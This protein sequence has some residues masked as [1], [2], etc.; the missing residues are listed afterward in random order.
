MKQIIYLLFFLLVYL[1]SY[2]QHAFKGKVYADVNQNGIIDKNEKGIA[3]VA[4]SNGDDVVLTDQN[5]MYTLPQRDECIVFVI[6]PSNFDLPKDPYY[7]HKFF[8]I[9]KPQGSPSDLKY[10]GSKATGPIPQ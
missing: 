3:N 1:P 6:K 7:H 10:P 5:G 9:H 2:S 8:Y 4:V